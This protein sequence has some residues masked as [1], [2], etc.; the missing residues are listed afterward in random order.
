[1]FLLMDV[2]CFQ[3]DIRGDLFG[4]L[5]AHPLSPLV[6]LHHIDAVEPVFPGMSRI[7]GLKHLFEAAHA[8]PA[9]ILQQTV[10]YDCTNSLTVSVSWGYAIQV[11]E[12]NKLLPDI[13]SLHRTFRPWRRGKNVSSS[14]YMFNTREYPKDQCKRPVVFFLHSVVT[15]PDGVWT[16]YMGHNVRNCSR[17]EVTQKLK[18]I[19]VFSKNLDLDIEQVQQVVS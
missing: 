19:S 4:M 3:V 2:L 5:S 13:L 17:R 9:S 6:S 10:C 7:N 12:G 11:Y 1:M 16:H 18:V 14:R 8:N 15:D